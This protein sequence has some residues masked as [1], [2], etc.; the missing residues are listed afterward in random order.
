[1][2]EAMDKRRTERMEGLFFTVT[3]YITM[4]LSLNLMIFLFSRNTVYDCS[5]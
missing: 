3:C 1:M 5:L 4:A 2:Q